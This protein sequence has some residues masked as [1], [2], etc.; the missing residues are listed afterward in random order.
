M[1]PKIPY[2]RN[3]VLTVL[4]LVIV[5]ICSAQDSSTIDYKLR[6]QIVVGGNVA[7]YS[8][9]M[10]GLYSL[11]YKDYPF[12]KFHFFNDNKQ[13]L[14]MDKVGHSFSCYY[15]GVAGIEMMKWAGYSKKQYSIIG[16]SFGFLIQTG[17]EVL[18]GFSTGWGASHGDI[19]A[20][21]VGSGLAI[22]Q[23]L[24][25]DEQRIWMK[26][27]YSASQYPQ[28][29]PNALGSNLPER[30][31]K[32]Y[33]AQTYW[34][35][36][37]VK[38][39]MKKDSKWPAWLNVAAGYGADGMV[40]GTDNTFISDDIE[41]DYTSIFKR[42]RQFYLSPDIDL[43]R[44]KTKRKGARALLVVANCIK[45]PMPALEYHTNEGIRAHWIHF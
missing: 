37:N 41:Y 11:W 1:L 24:L 2:W 19:A 14:Q 5:S 39:F 42:S 33:N 35:S 15:E 20:N 25:W 29:R 44:I 12:E 21:T 40:G 9:T 16:G 22:S 28:H 34:L 17:I 38:S 32:D 8:G 3:Q 36:A 13:W 43:T 10:I 45:F 7:A 26:Y 18:D 4:C 30:M 31:L 27:S 6:K 23:S